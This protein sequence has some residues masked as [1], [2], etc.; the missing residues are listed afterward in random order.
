M[1]TLAIMAPNVISAMEVVELVASADPFRRNSI[2]PRSSPLQ[3]KVTAT[4]NVNPITPSIYL[5]DIKCINRLRAAFIALGNKIFELYE[6]V[7]ER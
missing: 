6:F 7:R 2:L 5:R 4:E 1:E 3:A